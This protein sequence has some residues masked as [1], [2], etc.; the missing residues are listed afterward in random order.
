MGLVGNGVQLRLGDWGVTSVKLEVDDVVGRGRH[1]LPRRQEVLDPA[2]AAGHF[3][4]GLALPWLL[5]VVE[6]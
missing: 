1:L 2:H 6:D 3:A 5:Y 4:S